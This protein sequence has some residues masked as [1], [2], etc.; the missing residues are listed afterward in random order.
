LDEIIGGLRNLLYNLYCTPNV[1]IMGSGQ[2]GM[3]RACRI[4]RR[5]EQYMQIFGLK[6]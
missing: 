1:V 3:G 4:H 5:E 2:D 6:T